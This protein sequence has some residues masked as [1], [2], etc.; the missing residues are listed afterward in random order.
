M[1]SSQYGLTRIHNGVW[2][3]IYRQYHLAGFSCAAF[4]VFG[5]GRCEREQAEYIDRFFYMNTGRENALVEY[6]DWEKRVLDY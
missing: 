3:L 4:E 1:G 6:M 5:M 2:A